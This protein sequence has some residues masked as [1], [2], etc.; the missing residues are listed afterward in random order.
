[1]KTPKKS[2]EAKISPEHP[3]DGGEMDLHADFDWLAGAAQQVDQGENFEESAGGWRL[4]ESLKALRVQVDALAPMRSKASDGSIGDASHITR[5]SDHNPWVVFA[6]QGIVT[7]IDITNDPGHGCDAARLAE[8]LRLGRDPRIKYIISRRRIASAAPKGS[9][10]AWTWRTYTGINPHDKHVHI[11]VQP[12]AAQFDSTDQ[13][14]IEP[15]FNRN[16]LALGAA[17]AADPVAEIEAATAALVAL[18]GDPGVPL[19]IRLNA[20]TEGATSLLSTY[21][22]EVASRG[23]EAGDDMLEATAPSFQ[24]LAEEYGQLFAACTIPA[25]KTGEV[26]WHRQM[27]LKGRTRYEQTEKIS[28]VPWWFIG[29]CH[30]LE[31]SFN[32]NGHLH[33]GDPLAHRTV[34][35]PAGRPKVWNPPTDWVSSA[36]DAM[37]Y[38]GYAEAEDWS[39]TRSLYRWEAYNGWGSRNKGIHTPYLWSF[40]NHYTKGKYVKDHVFDPHAVSKQCGAAVMLKALQNASDVKL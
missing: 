32:F 4:A 30:A 2:R 38:Q 22:A 37:K 31:A 19:I 36:V 1:M 14:K 17:P 13:W 24:N 7:A 27:L 16:E 18:A 25:A 15:A 28:G 10:P 9:A 21:S 39:L 40:S 12:Q 35:V 6:G 3:L 5:D 11:S 26:A 20:L 33:N 8:A 34:Q 23:G 29:I